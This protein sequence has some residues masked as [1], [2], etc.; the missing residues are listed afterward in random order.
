MFGSLGFNGNVVLVLRRQ[1]GRLS[2]VFFCLLHRRFEHLFARCSA[3]A[4]A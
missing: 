1:A 4:L 3:A 2:E